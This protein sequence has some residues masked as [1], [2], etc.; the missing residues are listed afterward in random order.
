[1]IGN[2]TKKLNQ[3]I[4]NKYIEKVKPLILKCI[5]QQQR[6]EQL[7][8]IPADSFSYDKKI[9]PYENYDSTIISDALKEL[10]L[11]K[12]VIIKHKDSPISVSLSEETF[13]SFLQNKHP[14]KNWLKI[15]FFDILGFILGLWGSITGTIALFLE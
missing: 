6:S 13:N 2:F 7:K 11:E 4:F 5:F 9:K 1:M 14:I 12:K 8:F 3:K 15:H 10:E